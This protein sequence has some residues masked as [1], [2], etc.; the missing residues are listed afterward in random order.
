[1]TR[2]M[3]CIHSPCLSKVKC[4]DVSS[5]VSISVCYLSP[6]VHNIETMRGHVGEPFVLSLHG[7]HVKLWHVHCP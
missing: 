5:I 7:Q 2:D 1:M 6:A 4:T 3:A